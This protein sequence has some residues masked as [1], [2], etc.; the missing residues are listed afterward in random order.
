MTHTP[1]NACSPDV[2]LSYITIVKLW[3]EV[4]WEEDETATDH[5]LSKFKLGGV[6]EAIE[7]FPC[8]CMNLA[9]QSPMARQVGSCAGD[10][11]KRE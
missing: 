6:V 3:R 8:E 7:S 10:Y 4:F 2:H 5:S 9:L 1:G 11:D